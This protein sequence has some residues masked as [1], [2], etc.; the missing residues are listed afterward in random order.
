MGQKDMAEKLLADYND[1]F[2]DIVNV[3]LFDGRDEVSEDDLVETK[4]KSQYKADDSKLHEQERDVAKILKKDNV[5]MVLLG[6]ENQTAID[7]DMPLRCLAYDGASYRSQ[8]LNKSAERYPVITVVLYFGMDRWDKS[9]HLSETVHVPEIWKPYFN[10]YQAHVFE[11]AYLSPEQVKM[12]KSDFGIVADY[13]VQKRMTGDYIG[14]SEDIRHIDEVMK[15][16]AVFADKRFM[17]NM[18]ISSSKR[19]PKNMCEVLDRIEEKGRAEG[20]TEGR[21]EGH[22]QGFEQ[23]MEIGM[24]KGQIIMLSDTFGYSDKEIANTLNIPVSKVNSVL[25]NR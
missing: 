25:K 7:A 18:V 9:R 4:V 20:R 24:L 23:G 6:L 15:L 3:L 19:R 1:V 12:F 2:A 17:D 21:I 11:I 16:L 5:K 14:S 8:L 10:D 13:F 22:K